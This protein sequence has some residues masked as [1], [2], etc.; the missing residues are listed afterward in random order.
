MS[1]TFRRNVAI[2]AVGQAL[3]LSVAVL[4]MTLGTILHF[5]SAPVFLGVGWNFAFIG[6]TALLTQTCQPE[7]QLKVQAINEFAIFGLV[8]VATLSAGWL[9]DRFGW[10]TL[11]LAVL[12]LLG[13]ALLAAIGIERRLRQASTLA[14]NNSRRPT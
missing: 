8:A 9:Y 2:L 7:E 1:P 10:F 12:P 4:A 11:N 6:G 3:M 5:L 14:L 13:V